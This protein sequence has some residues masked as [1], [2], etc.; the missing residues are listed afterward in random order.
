MA[1]KRKVNREYQQL[2]KRRKSLEFF[3]AENGLKGR[4]SQSTFKDE[5]SFDIEIM[6]PYER[7]VTKYWVAYGSE[8]DRRGTEDT[9]VIDYNYIGY[10]RVDNV[11]SK[12]KQELKDEI[13]GSLL[14]LIFQA[15]MEE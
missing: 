3:I 10:I 7:N 4:T 5:V 13:K 8:G 6:S 14:P 2:L 15:T 1:K 12:S 9:I 11:L